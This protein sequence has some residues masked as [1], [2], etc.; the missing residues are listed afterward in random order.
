MTGAFHPPAATAVQADNAPVRRTAGCGGLAGGDEKVQ[1]P[2]PILLLNGDVAGAD[3]TVA[4]LIKLR[5]RLLAAALGRR[6]GL[7]FRLNRSGYR[8]Q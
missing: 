5:P 2:E 3:A 7:G 8:L 1:R 6:A 4:V